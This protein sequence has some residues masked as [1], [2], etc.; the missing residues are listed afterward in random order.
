MS[1]ES[2]GQPCMVNLSAS[3]NQTIEE[4]NSKESNCDSTKTL[5]KDAKKNGLKANLNHREHPDATC[6]KFSAK[7]LNNCKQKI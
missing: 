3:L 5:A 6:P 2:Q 4:R 1:Q 7:I